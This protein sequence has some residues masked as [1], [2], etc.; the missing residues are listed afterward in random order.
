ML[1]ATPRAGE[2]RF[3][4]WSTTA[5][6]ARVVLFDPTNPAGPPLATHPMEARGEGLFDCVLPGVGSGALYG[7][8]LDGRKLSDPFGRFFPLGVGGPAMVVEPRYEWRSAPRPPPRAGEIVYELHVGAFTPEGTYAAA[9]DKLQELAALGVTTVELMPLT[10][11]AGERGWG[12]DAAFHFAPFAPYGTPDQ[13]RAFV[14]R[15]HT[16]RMSVV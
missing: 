5:E 14:D 2:T 13:L 16:L 1:G 15:A 4:L 10:A 6:D 7:F 8:A 3:A 9:F 11:F 12:Y